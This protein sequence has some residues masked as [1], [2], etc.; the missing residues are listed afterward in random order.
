MPLIKDFAASVDTA[1]A[2]LLNQKDYPCIAA[3][4]ALHDAQ[5]RI[6]LYSGLGTGASSKKL[7]QDLTQFKAEQT[8]TKSPYLSFWAVFDDTAPASEKEFEDAMWSELSALSSSSPEAARPDPKFSSDPADKNFCFS[9]AGDAYFIVG[10]HP[11]SSRLARRFPFPSMIFNLYEQFEALGDGYEPMV[12]T[13]RKRDRQFQGSVNPTV[14]RWA[15][16]WESIQFSG[17]EN[18]PDWKCPFHRS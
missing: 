10:M 11:Q 6:G 2:D 12:K 8:A 7:T 9:F 15:D 4:A 1:I 16:R 14:K 17:R 13:N 3:V 5:L 18:P